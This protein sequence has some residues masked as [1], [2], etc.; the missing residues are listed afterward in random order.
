MSLAWI[1]KYVQ[2]VDE[3]LFVA[4]EN[5]KSLTAKID[6]LQGTQSTYSNIDWNSPVA[7]IQIQLLNAKRALKTA[8][9]NKELIEDEISSIGSEAVYLKPEIKV[10]IPDLMKIYG[11][12]QEL[13]EQLIFTLSVN[14][15]ESILREMIE[16]TIF[17]NLPM[18]DI[19]QSKTTLGYGGVGTVYQNTNSPEIVYKTMIVNTSM[20]SRSLSIGNRRPG[21]RDYLV[22]SFINAI[23]TIDPETRPYISNLYSV[24]R[25]G[26]PGGSDT[27]I[28]L[29]ME[30][31]YP[32]FD[33]EKTDKDILN[34]YKNAE[35]ILKILNM[36]YQF[37]HGD[38]HSNNIMKT[39]NGSMKLIDFGFSR[40]T[41]AGIEFSS[42]FSGYNEATNMEYLIERTQTMIKDQDLRKRIQMEKNTW[43]T[44]GKRTGGKYK[45]IKRKNGKSTRK[46]RNYS[47]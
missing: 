43:R 24:F 16:K 34:I 31:L 1:D 37:T 47:V 12:S 4:E 2:Q 11:L 23:L 42:S 29:K 46:L 44:G 21:L 3:Q 13:I 39:K 9:L 40:I 26:S 6:S 27:G 10:L 25:Y 33:N 15:T 41:L 8:K 17:D 5:F 22:E 14:T 30:K 7:S 36:K 20:M 28:V 32:L 35:E 18:I 19:Q 45:T 38:F